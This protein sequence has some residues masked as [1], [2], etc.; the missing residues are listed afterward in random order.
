MVIHERAFK[1]ST[2]YPY[3]CFIFQ[4]CREAG[5]PIWNYNRL[6]SPMR[7]V[8]IGLIKDEANVAAPQRGPRVKMPLLC[9]NLANIVE[10]AQGIDPTTFDTFDTTP[11][12]YTHD[13]SRD[14]SSS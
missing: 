1:T 4:I 9:E 13:A 10:L 8:D 6:H 3:A 2:T 14:P 11:E 12:D 5:V 7:T